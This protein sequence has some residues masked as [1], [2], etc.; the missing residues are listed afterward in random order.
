[1]FG[2][3]QIYLTFKVVI[4][5]FKNKEKCAVSNLDSRSPGIG[6]LYVPNFIAKVPVYAHEAWSEVPDM[7]AAFGSDGFW[8]QELTW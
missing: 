1:M 4:F 5:S 6:Q 2:M 8:L 3:K 7:A